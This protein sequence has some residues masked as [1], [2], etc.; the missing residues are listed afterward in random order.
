M[1]FVSG[2]SSFTRFCPL[3]N[4]TSSTCS[5]T[6]Q[7]FR[8]RMTI[9]SPTPAASPPS[10]SPLEVASPSEE[11]AQRISGEWTGTECFFSAINGE[12]KTIPERYVPDAYRDW[13][14][15]IHAFETVAA[16][17]VRDDDV[18]RLKHLR[19]LPSV[20]CEADA[21][22]T[23]EILHEIN[24]STPSEARF[25]QGDSSYVSKDSFCM[26]HPDGKNRVRISAEKYRTIG[27]VVEEWEAV[28]NDAQVLPG[29]SGA[30]VAFGKEP[31][32]EPKD[33]GTWEIKNQVGSVEQLKIRKKFELPRGIS[34]EIDEDDRI[35]KTS[36]AF[37]EDQSERIVLERSLDED[38]DLNGASWRIETLA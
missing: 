26:Y 33:N 38:G 2:F 14:V 17:K 11:F 1:A 21:V 20:G 19:V 29:C 22:S 27:V 4:S 28:W 23:E 36:W 35:L 34:V 15:E 10:S 30:P 3:E 5:T 9:A 13:G 37:N 16:S 32:G 31:I 6:R 25:F 8:L 7:R 12:C 24:L 18:L